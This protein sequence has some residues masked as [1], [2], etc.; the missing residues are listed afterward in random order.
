M[1]MPNWMPV[2]LY[3]VCLMVFLAVYA[4]GHM[5]DGVGRLPFVML[6]SLTAIMLVTDLISRCFIYE[7][8][9]H[10]LVVSSTCITFVMLP[11]IGAEW[12]QYVRSLLT[13][14]ERVNT[15][16]L[17]YVVNIIAA[18]GIIVALLSPVTNW[19]FY[20][21]PSGAYYRGDLFPVPAFCAFLIMVVAEVFLVMCVRSLGRHALSMLL[22]FILPPLA[23]AAMS[24]VLGSI[25]WIPLGISLSM[26]VLFVNIQTTG[27][28]TDYLTG[29][30]NRKKA[31]ELLED[32]I[33]RVAS[34]HRFAAI[35]IDVDDFKKINDTLGHA[36]GD[37]ALADTAHLLQDSVR[38]GDAV[39]RFGG[40]EF[41]VLLDVEKESELT[42]VIER[43][44]KAEA[45][46][47][48]SDKRYQLRLSKG[49][50]FFDPERFESAQAYEEHLDYLMYANKQQRK[51]L[52][53]GN[54]DAAVVENRRGA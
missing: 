2:I 47:N 28:G 39:A 4:W 20:F 18:V 49:Y 30:H 3:A 40:D 25:P 34:G 17:D 11:A 19:V 43:I 41:F 8:F 37:V 14:E 29:L 22:S 27:M 33:S 50:D 36:V 7:G 5:D 23:G 24:L 13:A 51:A 45:E 9:P 26:V 16:Y 32:R 44:E 52:A 31:E 6:A 38:A 42:S 54:A 12:Y 21:D 48:A 46:F 15:R 10:M 53:A 35:M 1:D